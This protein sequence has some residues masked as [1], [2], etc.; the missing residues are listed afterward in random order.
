MRKLISILTFIIFLATSCTKNADHL[1][2]NGTVKDFTGLDGCGLMI[3]LDAG[4]RLEIISLPSNTTLIADR[5]VE[6]KYKPVPRASACMAGTTAE[7]I[8]LRYL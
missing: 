3:V 1:E 4:D 7:I 8:S 2:A 5:R 6:V